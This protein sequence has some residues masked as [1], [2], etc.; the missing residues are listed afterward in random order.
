LEL[1][2]IRHDHFVTLVNEEIMD[3]RRVRARL[4]R[5][6]HALTLREESLESAATRLH[7]F[8]EDRRPRRVQNADRALL[9]AEIDSRRERRDVI[10]VHGQPPWA[11]RP[12][13]TNWGPQGTPRQEAGL[14][15]P[16]LRF[17]VLS[18]SA[19]CPPRGA[20]RGTPSGA[21]PPS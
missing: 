15:I 2:S 16:S 10:L 20:R 5:Y 18:V 3:P 19:A 12:A 17:A 11:S 8:F 7:D 4:D 9:V 14:F 21:P 6:A 13:V 1:A